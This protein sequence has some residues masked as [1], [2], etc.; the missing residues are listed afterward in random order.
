MGLSKRLE[1]TSMDLGLKD[2]VALVAA[3]S[4][5]LGYGV[6][7]ALAKEGARVSICSREESAVQQAAE[8]LHRET[9]AD[10]LPVACDV[11]DATSILNWV[12]Q[13]VQKWGRVDALLVNAGGP[14]AGPFKSFTDEQCQAAFVLTLLS[15]ILMIRSVLPHMPGGGAILTVTSASVIEPHD[16][17]ILSTTMRSGVT[18]LVK[19]LSDELAPDGIRV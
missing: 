18:G 13:T 3:A 6:A 8:R 15:T 17:L 9:G 14:P 10:V 11:R 1:H 5:G 19:A 7:R 12:D 16:N 2:K 4:K